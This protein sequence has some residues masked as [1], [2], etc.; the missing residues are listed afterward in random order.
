MTDPE[1]PTEPDWTRWAKVS[2][3]D[4]LQGMPYM[5]RTSDDPSSPWR[6][7][8]TQSD[9]F[10]HEELPP[11]NEDEPNR[12]IPFHTTTIE[13]YFDNSQRVLNDTDD[14]EVGLIR[15][16]WWRPEQELPEWP[17]RDEAGS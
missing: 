12:V 4:E 6:N 2:D 5:L 14:I 7:V 11:V 9:Q 3:L 16:P 10:W 15:P 17:R 8:K 1:I 13:F